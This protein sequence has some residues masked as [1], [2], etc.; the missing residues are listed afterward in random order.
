MHPRDVAYTVRGAGRF[1]FDMLRYDAVYP[2]SSPDA[3]SLGRELH[4]PD[5]D[6]P[7]EIHLRGAA[8]TRERWQS[9]GWGVV[10]GPTKAA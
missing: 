5:Y 10:S 6:Q 4:D 7:R 1:P 8:C 2:C 9:F 3:V